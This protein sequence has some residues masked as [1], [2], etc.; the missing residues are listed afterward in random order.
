MIESALAKNGSLIHLK[1][2]KFLASS[3]DPQKEAEAW[4]LTCK[5]RAKCARAVFILGLG[6]GYHIEVVKREL[7]EAKIVVIEP[8]QELV[9]VYQSTNSTELEINCEA[10]WRKLFNYSSVSSGVQ[11]TYAV[12]LHPPSYNVEKE[13]FGNAYKFLLARSV[14]GLFALFKSRPDLLS[15]LDEAKLTDLARSTD[16]VS[17]RTITKAMKATAYADENRRIWKVLEELIA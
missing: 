5:P 6:S 9:N 8:D 2:G 13:Y 4:W 14:D 3:F 16:P 7:P 11:K 1:D 15:E 17:I 10:D 12:L